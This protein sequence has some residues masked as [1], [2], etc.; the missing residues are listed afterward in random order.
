MSDAQDAGEFFCRVRNRPI[1]WNIASFSSQK[2]CYWLTILSVIVLNGLPTLLLMVA[3][4]VPHLL[5]EL[6]SRVLKSLHHGQV[7]PGR[8]E[9]FSCGLGLTAP[10]LYLKIVVCLLSSAPK[11][12]Y[13]SQSMRLSEVNEVVGHQCTCIGNTNKC[14]NQRGSVSGGAKRRV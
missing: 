11:S 12:R 2:T 3:L 4:A 14:R 13:L 7:L 10:V 6:L 8:N 9:Q 5:L 1:G